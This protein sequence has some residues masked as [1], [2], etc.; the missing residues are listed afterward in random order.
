MANLE[1][2]DS[3]LGSVIEG[4][5]VVATDVL[6][7]PLWY[8]ARVVFK[9]TILETTEAILKE[10]HEFL[11]TQLQ[12]NSKNRDL[13]EFAF[14]IIF[15]WFRTFIALEVTLIAPNPVTAGLTAYY[16]GETALTHLRRIGWGKAH[17]AFDK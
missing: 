15:G 13:D 5:K 2:K 16:A 11:G 3:L 12:W 6:V 17:N 14:P 9:P 4:G 7:K 1:K 10:R 8:T